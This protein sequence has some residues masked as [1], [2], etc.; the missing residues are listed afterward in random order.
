MLVRDFIADQ[1]IIKNCIKIISIMDFLPKKYDQE[2]TDL[3]LKKHYVIRYVM[4]LT[5]V[6]ATQSNVPN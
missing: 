3:A 1:F 6:I 4:G 2:R 5:S